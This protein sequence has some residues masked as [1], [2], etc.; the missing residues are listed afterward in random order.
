MLERANGPPSMT[1]P[2]T[3]KH[4]R[5]SATVA[6]SRGPARS[7]AQISGRM[8]KNASAARSAVCSKRGL[9][10]TMPTASAVTRSATDAVSMA[11]AGFRRH[12]R[13]ACSQA[14]LR[15]AS[16]GLSAR[17]RRKSSAN[18]AADG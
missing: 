8:A 6:V 15:R 4:A 18:S 3:A 14:V 13:Q 2:Q 11:T 5:M 10:A 1:V 16:I 9:K 12:Q 7:A 17:N